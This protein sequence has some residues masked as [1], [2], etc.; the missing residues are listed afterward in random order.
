MRSMPVRRSVKSLGCQ[1]LNCECNKFGLSFSAVTRLPHPIMKSQRGAAV[2]FVLL[3]VIVLATAVFA[4]SRA[5]HVESRR[6]QNFRDGVRAFYLARAGVEYAVSLLEKDDTPYD[7]LLDEWA[8]GPHDIDFEGG[9]VQV[10]IQDQER[11]LNVNF[12]APSGGGGD[13]YV[14]VFQRLFDELGISKTFLL[15]LKDWIDIDDE[16][17]TP[18]SEGPYYEALPHPYPVKN[19]PLDT[20]YELT[21]VG[22]ME[23]DALE[24]LGIA[25]HRVHMKID[26]NPYLTVQSS[27]EVNINTADAVV[28][29]ALSTSIT[30]DVAHEI[31]AYR[32][33]HPFEQASDLRDLP[34]VRDIF[35][36]IQD[37]ITTS[38]TNFLIT[39]TGKVNRVERSISAHVERTEGKVSL[40]Y[41]V[42]Q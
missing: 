39:S 14:E 35:G 12:L 31:V 30:N 7:T 10:H 23:D 4:F 37:M 18:G 15:Y 11:K 17:A 16:E 19:A 20:L 33:I 24:K 1:R 34:V 22:G 41:W 21:A 42:V 26:E 3:V 38:S 25:A 5:S 9:R 13:T 28:L 2:V 40:K 6:A 32:E 36:E 8:A 29:A 27:G